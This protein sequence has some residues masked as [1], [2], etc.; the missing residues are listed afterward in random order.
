MRC[1]PMC[2]EHHQTIVKHISVW[3]ILF[4]QEVNELSD[5]HFM[6]WNYL[7]FALGIVL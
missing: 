7:Y 3:V 4:D 5:L 2:A 6:K 1:E